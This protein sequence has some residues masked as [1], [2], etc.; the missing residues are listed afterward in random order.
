MKTRIFILVCIILYVTAHLSMAQ[1]C[2][3]DINYYL[4][5]VTSFKSTEDSAELIPIMKCIS[6]PAWFY[7]NHPDSFWSADFNAS[8]YEKTW[9]DY[10]SVVKI[11][12]P[13]TN[14]SIDNLRLETSA[15]L[16]YYDFPPS[17]QILKNYPDGPFKAVLFAI[18]NDTTTIGWVEDR[19][20]KALAKAQI[21]PEISERDRMIYLGLLYHIAM[22]RAIPFLNRL[23]KYEASDKLRA[24]AMKAEQ[25]IK[26]LHLEI[27]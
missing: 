3:H 1:E 10:L 4:S 19:Y 5:Q 26:S 14:S 12:V 16:A 17:D 9:R 13:F 20:D 15:A 18:L 22:P 7:V 11:L 2:P 24:A 6:S 25:R 27:K 8:I 23:I 21:N